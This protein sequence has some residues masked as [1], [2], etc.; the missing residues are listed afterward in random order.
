MWVVLRYFRLAAPVSRFG[1]FWHA[2]H[3]NGVKTSDWE[4]EPNRPHGFTNICAVMDDTVNSDV[5]WIWITRFGESHIVLPVALTL[6][7][8][9]ALVNA[10]RSARSWAWALGVAIVVTVVSKIA[11]MGWGLGSEALDFTGISGHAML[12][13]AVYPVLGHVFARRRLGSTAWWGA[14]LGYGLAALIAV[15]RVIINAH[16]VSEAMAG[17][18]LGGLVSACA[19]GLMV[20]T[21]ARIPRWV[22]LVGMAWLLAMPMMVRSSGA[23]GTLIKVALALSH[24]TEPYHRH[25]LH[26][27]ALVK[28]LHREEV[29]LLGH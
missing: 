23:H 2:G 3:K 29:I 27:A 11:F 22:W 7:L 5:F 6:V 12:S 28:P 4:G 17:F 26:R 16:S 1:K 10:D 9:F 18:V 15:S 13:A 21:K 24:R 14:A 8:A 19:M 20:R 25:D